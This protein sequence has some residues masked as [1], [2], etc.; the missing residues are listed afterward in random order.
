MAGDGF[1]IR[2][3]ITKY[4]K[5][6]T[7][8][9][10]FKYLLIFSDRLRLTIRDGWLNQFTRSKLT[11]SNQILVKGEKQMTVKEKDCL[12]SVGLAALFLIF[13]LAIISNIDA[14]VVGLEAGFNSL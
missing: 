3:K 2:G 4:E 6:T 12:I 13:A 5:K 11:T 7:T 1:Y 10:E 8:Y 9:D 14:I